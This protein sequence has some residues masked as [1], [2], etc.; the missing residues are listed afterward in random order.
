MNPKTIYCDACKGRPAIVD[1]DTGEEDDQVYP[2]SLLAVRQVVLYRQP[3]PSCG[4]D[5]V[6]D[7]RLE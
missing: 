6:R 5:P 1:R 4:R 2:S 7:S 3:A